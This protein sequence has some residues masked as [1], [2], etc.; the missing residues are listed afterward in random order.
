MSD[1]LL[2]AAHAINDAI[3][4]EGPAPTLHSV[5]MMRS[6]VLWPTLWLAID[7]LRAALA[8]APCDPTTAATRLAVVETECASIDAALEAQELLG[9]AIDALAVDCVC[10]FLP[11]QLLHNDLHVDPS[12]PEC[13]SNI[14]LETLELEVYLDSGGDDA[15][16]ACVREALEER[17]VAQREAK[18]S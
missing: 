10:P 5:V 9:A 11:D 16:R 6:R 15:C 1:E 8:D 3:T 13:Y 17:V 2:K 14:A 12:D 18:Q 4:N 7:R